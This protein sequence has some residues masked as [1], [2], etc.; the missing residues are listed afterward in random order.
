MPFSDYLLYAVHGAFWAS[1]GVT[2]LIVRNGSAP[3]P[4]A[5]PTR[6]APFS[7]ALLFFHMLGFGTMYF[8]VGQ[9]VVSG[10][11]PEL[12][13]FQ[14]L[15]GTAVM[16]LG[17]ALMCWSLAFF[18]SWRFR[19]QLD[20]GHELAT[21]GPF[22]ITR[23]PIYAGINLL[24]IGT[25]LWVPTPILLAAVVLLIVGGD[26][27]ARAEEK[28]LVEAFGD[29]YRAYMAKTKRFLPGLY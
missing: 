9:A 10:Q 12:F 14:R 15:A 23:H 4:P 20:A 8:G 5:S 26:L 7:R 2:R 6:T 25:A 29:R 27:R 24:G 3:Q 19:A 21:G 28:L 13:A 16:S 17:A 11:V 22:A 18:R 1:F